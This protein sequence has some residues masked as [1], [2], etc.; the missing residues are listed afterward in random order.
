MF[1]VLSNCISFYLQ[2][3]AIFTKRRPKIIGEIFYGSSQCLGKMSLHIS[4]NQP[5]SSFQVIF[6]M[7]K[8]RRLVLAKVV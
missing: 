1:N 7:E 4:Q 6:I 2:S 8:S 3:I 5:W